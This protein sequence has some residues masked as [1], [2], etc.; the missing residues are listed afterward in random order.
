MTDLPVVIVGAGVT[1]LVAATRLRQAGREVVV[2]EASET[3]GGVVRTEHV[4]GY[5][6]EHGPQSMRAPTA[7]CWRWFEAQEL[8]QHAL[9]ADDLASRRYVLCDG[10]LEALPTRLLGA[11]RSPLIGPR[12]LAR[13]LLEPLVSRGANPQESLAS[14]LTRRF[15]GTV[16]GP[17]ADAFTAGIV[18]GDPTQIEAQSLLPQL[19]EME[20]KYGSLLWASLRA[21][22]RASVGQPKVPTTFRGG[23]QQLTD[24][25]T[26]NLGDCVRTNHAVQRVRRD[27]TNTLIC[28]LEGESIAAAEVIFTVPPAVAS[29]LWP[30]AAWWDVPTEPIAS[31]HLGWSARSLESRRDGFG[32][33]SPRRERPDVLGAIWVSS[34]FPTHAPNGHTLTRLMIGGDRDPSAVNESDEALIERAQRV[35]TEVEGVTE[36][37][38]FAHVVRL[39]AGIPQYRPGHA[40]RLQALRASLPDDVQVCG[41]FYDGVGLSARLQSDVSR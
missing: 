23:M 33:L 25:L 3:A 41:W 19:T 27:G 28:E 20:S 34:L 13:I 38:T 18:A 39:E 15:G 31:V 24:S 40:G 17:I 29:R 8:T 14:F 30:D 12:A 37:P 22:K 36:A 6:V 21:P 11:L 4:Q 2:L 32:W 10:R 9:P 16:G 26:Q 1:G 35:L 7:D 5:I